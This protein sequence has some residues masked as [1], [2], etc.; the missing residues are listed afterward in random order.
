MICGA[1]NFQNDDQNKFC[2]NCGVPLEQ[3]ALQSNDSNEELEQNDNIITTS[4]QQETLQVEDVQQSQDDLSEGDVTIPQAETDDETAEQPA[5]Q[6]EERE[7]LLGE[8][9]EQETLEQ[10]MPTPK[11][12][13][14]L[15]IV[16]LVSSVLFVTL[17]A[18]MMFWES[19]NKEREIE[20]V[21]EVSEEKE[22]PLEAIYMQV[23]EM[24]IYPNQL[25][26]VDYYVYPEQASTNDLVWK[27][28]NPN[29]SVNSSGYIMSTKENSEGVITLSDKSGEIKA[30]MNVTVG[31]EEEVFQQ[32][33]TYIQNEMDSGIAPL[34]Y[35]KEHFFVGKNHDES[36]IEDNVVKHFAKVEEDLNTY[37]IVQKQF[38]NSASKNIVDVDVYMKRGTNEIHKIVAIEHMSDERLKIS[39][40]Y[41]NN[42]KLGFHFERFENYYRPVAARQDFPGV[43]AYIFNDALLRY[44]DII[45]VGAGFEKTDYSIKKDTISWKKF[46]YD[47]IDEDDVNKEM[48]SYE[49]AGDD[50]EETKHQQDRYFAEEQRI[51]NAGY[52][53]YRA[54]VE[55]PALMK[56]SGYVAYPDAGGAANVPV[57]VFSEKMQMLIGEAYTDADGYYEI[58]VPQNQGEYRIYTQHDSYVS[59]TIYSIDSA[60]GIS[61]AMQETIY[62]FPNNSDYYTVNL[63]LFDA[64]SG[65]SLYDSLY[66]DYDDSMSS[67]DYYDSDYED[68]EYDE[69]YEEVET[70]PTPVYAKVLVRN[71][72]NNKEGRVIY[73]NEINIF[74]VHELTL[75][76]APGNYTVE[77]RIAG[78]ERNYFTL[79]TVRDGMQVQSNIVPKITGNEM[80]VVLTWLD[81]PRDLDS[82]LFF[83]DNGHIA[84]YNSEYKTSFLDVDDTDGY[85]PETITLKDIT[86]GTYK[87]YVADYTNL[88]NNH[89]TSNEM[90]NSFARVDVYTKNGTKSFTV[91]RNQQAVIWQVFNISNGQIVPIQRVYNNVQDYKWWSQDK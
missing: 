15:N 84:Y 49:K 52:N 23:D 73:E 90:S 82:H 51:V 1:C 43:R 39:D 59:T 61:N 14:V 50:A 45:E 33:M 42:G 22:L 20:Q 16:G 68:E 35:N 41:F 4:E 25:K 71:G 8:P 67:D 46:A 78:Y 66:N 63:N 64:I 60:Q 55:Q 24:K 48:S 31:K 54:V 29:I 11:K 80:R 19:D 75:Q 3:T 53:L 18:V 7:V 2:S 86:N 6:Q 76:L 36:L 37:A 28:S 10:I 65:S 44:R 77:V 32:T 5:E 83:P 38:I 89:L 70:G 26:R 17:A 85:G 9:S 40:Y 62:L 13:K 27:S 87:Y 56:L 79:S 12:Q 21:K 34:N 47:D 57:K 81:S 72:I 69:E 88:S 58:I 91:P 30:A 74:D